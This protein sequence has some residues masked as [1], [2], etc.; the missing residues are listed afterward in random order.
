MAIVFEAEHTHLYPGHEGWLAGAAPTGTG[1]SSLIALSDGVM[2]GGVL[3]RADSGRW[4]LGVDPY[5]TAAG[6]AIPAK[7]W[8]VAFR[9]EDG[10]TRFRIERKLAVPSG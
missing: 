6:T 7:R 9:E 3:T 10:R 4:E 5:S 2:V 1:A 8:Q